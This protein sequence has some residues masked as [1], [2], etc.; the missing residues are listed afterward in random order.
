M[1]MQCRF[2]GTRAGV[3]KSLAEFCPK[4]STGEDKVPHMTD[5][6]Q[7]EAVRALVQ[8]EV[9]ALDT[10]HN[11]ACVIVEATAHKG[12]RSIQVTVFPRDLHL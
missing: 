2:E 11:G 1:S 6:T 4:P 12:G 7:V 3:L 5:R 10:K 9:D 8:S